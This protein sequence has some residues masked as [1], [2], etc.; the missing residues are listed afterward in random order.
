MRNH[1]YEMLAKEYKQINVTPFM[2]VM[3]RTL[4]IPQDETEREEGEVI[5]DKRKTGRR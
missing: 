1:G 4:F 3:K 5:C 2:D